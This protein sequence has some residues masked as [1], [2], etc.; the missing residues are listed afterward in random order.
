[1]FENDLRH[2]SGILLWEERRDKLLHW[3]SVRKI[4]ANVRLTNPN[5]L[6]TFFKNNDYKQYAYSVYINRTVVYLDVTKFVVI[7]I[8]TN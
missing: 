6:H 7:Q 8:D 3:H 2:G 5:L 1:M 4:H